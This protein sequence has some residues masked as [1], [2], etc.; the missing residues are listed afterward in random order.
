MML[1]LN[2]SR[3]IFN[4]GLIEWLCNLAVEE[5]GSFLHLPGDLRGYGGFPQRFRLFNFFI[6]KFI[7][8][9]DYNKQSSNNYPT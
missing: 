7:G 2:T 8:S 5:H 6:G 4:R 3:F 1:V 9:T